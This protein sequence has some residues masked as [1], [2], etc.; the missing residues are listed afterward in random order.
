VVLVT[1]P[2]WGLE[3][4]IFNNSSLSIPPFGPRLRAFWYIRK[5]SSLRK[6]SSS[7]NNAPMVQP[8]NNNTAQNPVGHFMV[9]TG[10]VIEYQNSGKILIIKRNSKE[11][12]HGETWEIPYG[13]MDQFETPETGLTREV[14]EETGLSSIKI[15]KLLTAWH[16]FRGPEKVENE[17]VG[18]TYHCQSE[19]EAVQL[20]AEHTAF[21]W[22]SPQEA[23]NLI[24]VE[25][26]RRDVQAFI[27]EK[28]KYSALIGTKVI[29]MGVGA[30]IFNDKQEML[31]TLRGQKAKN[32]RGTW[33]IPGGA[34]EF[35]ETLQEGLK[36]EIW[37]ELG[38]EIQPQEMLQVCD[39]LLP[40]EGQHWVSP[41][42]IC[43]ITSGVPKILE[44]EKCAQ[45]GWF[46]LEEAKK[47]P[48]SKVT[49]SDL[50]V[51][52]DRQKSSAKAK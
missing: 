4:K 3:Q 35:G 1:D 39:H 24:T 8:N 14:T 10:A 6:P 36:R 5:Q 45:I 33:E 40:D 26:I 21:R 29:G 12:W 49:Q 11:D 15:L 46:S 37:E 42:F 51:L 41:T 30:L 25:G 22:V 27:A 23:L 7:G 19:T 16:I 31:L 13:R 32:E 48:L 2:E 47:L 20:S 43:K 52:E 9:A 44:P 28:K 17:L 18:I 38:I 34:V 50:H